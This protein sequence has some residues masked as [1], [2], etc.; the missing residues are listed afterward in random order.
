ME[1]TLKNAYREVNQILNLLGNG[2][3]QKIPS[4]ILTL[5]EQN[6]EATS[7]E[8]DSK[9]N[10]ANWSNA[11]K[12]G[13]ISRNALVILSILNMK[14]WASEE[15]KQRLKAIYYENEKEYQDKINCYKS[16]DWIKRSKIG[17]DAQE[18]VSLVKIQEDSI[19]TKI[20]MFLKSL[21]SKRK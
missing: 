11:I 13:K 18:E 3:K 5:F 15:E 12:N 17:E 4:K 2:Y 8:D 21:V 14:Y 10:I 7:L 20:K 1:T 19:W 6:G 9:K 16:Q